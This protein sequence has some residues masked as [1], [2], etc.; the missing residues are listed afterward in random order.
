MK[1]TDTNSCYLLPKIRECK[2]GAQTFQCG[3]QGKKREKGVLWATQKIEGDTT[4]TNRSL[5]VPLSKPHS[6][7]L[8]Y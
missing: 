8:N 4:E 1:P 6:F 7:K 5:T 2:S 3:R